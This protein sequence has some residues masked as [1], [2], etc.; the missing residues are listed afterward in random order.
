MRYT[1]V[2]E[3]YLNRF[4]NMNPVIS[5]L[6]ISIAKP[7][8]LFSS[9]FLGHSFSTYFTESLLLALR[10][11]CSQIL[12]YSLRSYHLICQL[13]PPPDDHQWYQQYISATYLL[14]QWC[15]VISC[16]YCTWICNPDEGLRRDSSLSLQTKVSD[17]ARIKIHLW[18]ITLLKV[19]ERGLVLCLRYYRKS[20]KCRGRKNHIEKIPSKY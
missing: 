20:L 12:H 17:H 11:V 2:I 9:G 8:S 18:V 7:F 14:K 13:D 10:Y 15:S 5:G 6:S 16:L 19:R 3:A 1:D 4:K